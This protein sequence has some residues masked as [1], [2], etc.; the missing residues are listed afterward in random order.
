MQWRGVV[1]A[2]VD[3]QTPKMQGEDARS[4]SMECV[5][6]SLVMTLKGAVQVNNNRRE[7]RKY[8]PGIR[9]NYGM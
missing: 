4:R 3:A 2:D 8:V 5:S 6:E 1:S 7:R 9:T